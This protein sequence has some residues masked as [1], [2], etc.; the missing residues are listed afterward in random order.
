MLEQGKISPVQMALLMIPAIIATV[1]LLVPSITAKHAHHDLWLSPIWASVTGFFVVFL[2]YKLNKLF[3]KQTIIEYS[4]HAL[5]KIL[6]KL[7][8]GIFL[9]FYFHATGI[10]VREYGEFVSGAA[11]FHT[12]MAV[13]IG[14]MVLVCSF[15]V[16]GGLE[17]MGRASEI[18]VP[19]VILLYILLFILLIKDLEVKNLFPIM[20][21]GF[22]PSLMGS[23]VPQSWYSEFILVSFL[24]PYVT[25]QKK[26]FKWGLIAV[27]IVLFLMV[28][29]NIMTLL[30][31]GNLT[32]SLTYP[33]M[34]AARYISIADFLEHLES[35]VM[36]IWIAGT[37]I[38]ITVFY[39]VLALGTAQWLKLSDYRPIVLPIGFLILLQGLWAARDLQELSHFLATSGTIYILSIQVVIP[40]ILLLCASIR[41][42]LGQRKGNKQNETPV[43][44]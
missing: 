37:F 16:L 36:A 3:P 24:L 18:I 29:T 5:G 26:G 6:G 33:V 7:V 42:K 4:E 22:R 34:V 1:L 10:M 25:N 11:L 30:I 20:E 19:V 21:K 9:F 15:A 31:F 39:Y 40:F 8:G 43:N 32:S 12:P 44:H 17:V 38:K 14:T 23:I 35:I 13:I 28:L 27:F 2:S 41:K